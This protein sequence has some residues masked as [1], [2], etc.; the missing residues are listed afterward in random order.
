MIFLS[1]RLCLHRS[2]FVQV[3]SQYKC[4]IDKQ[5]WFSTYDNI[6][7][8]TITLTAFRT[9]PILVPN[10]CTIRHITR[11]DFLA[12]FLRGAPLRNVVLFLR[13]KW[14]VRHTPPMDFGQANIFTEFACLD[15]VQA[16]LWVVRLVWTDIAFK[17]GT[18]IS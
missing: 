16:F 1:S 17:G 7:V 9:R 14:K 10:V 18:W 15:C 12:M 4:E 5:R 3:I 6:I 11:S 13:T 8:A 2:K